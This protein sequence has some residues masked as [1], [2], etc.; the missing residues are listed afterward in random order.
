MTPSWPNQ[1]QWP[2]TWFMS[3]PWPTY[4]Q[5][6]TSSSPQPCS[7][8]LGQNPR[9]AYIS[10]HNPVAAQAP[11]SPTAPN[12]ELIPTTLAHTFNTDTLAVP[13]DVG[14]YMDT[15]ATAHLMTAQ[16]G[17][18]ST[19]TP[20]ADLPLITVG[21]GSLIP[22]TAIGHASISSP[23]RSL[24]LKNDLTTRAPLIRCHSIG[25]LYAVTPPRHFSGTRMDSFWINGTTLPTFSIAPTCLIANHLSW[26]SSV[27]NLHQTRHCVYGSSDLPLHACT[28]RTSFQCIETHSP[29]HKGTITQGLHITPSKT[30]TLT[31]YTDADWAGCP[32]TRRSTSSYCL[33]LGDNLILWSSKRQ[34]TVSQSSAEAEYRG[35]ANAVAELVWVRNLLLE[36]HYPITTTTL[37]YCDN[38]SAVY[39][40]TNPIQHQRTKHVEIDI[41]FVCEKVALGQVRMLHKP[42]SHQ[43]AD[44]FTKGLPSALFQDFRSSLRVG[45]PHALTEG[46][47]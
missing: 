47:Y 31:A 37:V 36:I 5:P 13:T 24:L 23:L 30:T 11:S 28:A 16:P 2:N 21:N 22:A 29:L 7:G 44:I 33:Y 12:S 18:I 19:L 32:N 27:P 40:S 6:P 26:S 45:E 41:H 15:G 9:S 38:V 43:Y 34:H 3:P 20:Q 39:L 46:G 10:T 25:L 17:K 4:P 8:L 14:W 35:V 42:S 1:A